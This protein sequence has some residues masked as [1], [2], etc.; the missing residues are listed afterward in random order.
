MSEPASVEETGDGPAGSVADSRVRDMRA[1]DLPGVLGIERACFPD[2]WPAA[3]FRRELARGA[4]GG[5]PRVLVEEGSV[6]AFAISWF[7][8]DEAN[9]ANLAVHPDHRRRGLAR[10]LLLD[11]LRTARRRESATVWLEVRAGNRA[12]QGLYVEAGFQPVAVRKGYYRR[13]GEDALVMVLDLAGR[14]E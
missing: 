6:R 7:A 10:A 5:Y 14:R 9:L 3:A 11:L 1:E 8:E 13:E 2:P 12:A 4:G